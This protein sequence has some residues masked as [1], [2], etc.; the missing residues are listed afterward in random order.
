[1]VNKFHIG[2]ELCG[3]DD[4]EKYFSFMDEEIND[5]ITYVKCNKCNLIYMNPR[6]DEEGLRHY[7]L[8]SYFTHSK[9]LAEHGEIKGSSH[10]LYRN[11]LVKFII[12]NYKNSESKTKSFLAQILLHIYNIVWGGFVLPNKKRGKLLDVGCGDGFE[13]FFFKQKGWNVYG[14]DID[15]ESIKTGLK[16][17]LNI[18]RG[19][20]INANYASNYFDVVRMMHSLEHVHNPNETINEINRILKPGGEFIIGIPNIK[21]A[22]TKI[23]PRNALVTDR[24]HLYVFSPETIKNMLDKNGIE[25]IKFKYTSAQIGLVSFSFNINNK[26]FRNIVVYNPLII[27]LFILIDYIQ[28][29]FF[30]G[31]GTMTISAT[32]KM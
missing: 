15:D 22:W 6:P 17:G 12:L 10:W 19:D 3:E 32:K 29:I 1:M 4:S 13:I 27:I 21:T 16:Y 8:S 5:K 9:L 14:V 7:Y 28:N 11:K 25:N 24:H 2:C 20:L 26:S 31:G 23:F 18:F 30:Y